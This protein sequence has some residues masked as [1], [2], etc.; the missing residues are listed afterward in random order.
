MGIKRFFFLFLVMASTTLP[1]R[2]V[3]ADSVRVQVQTL[4]ELRISLRED[5]HQTHE[6]LTQ[7]L[8]DYSLA[9]RDMMDRINRNQ[10]VLDPERDRCGV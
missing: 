6:E 1:L 4:D 2:A 3:S 8:D 7:F 5:Y 9:H 10:P